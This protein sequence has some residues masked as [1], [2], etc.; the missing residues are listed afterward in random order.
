MPRAT[1]DRYVQRWEQSLQPTEGNCLSE[2]ISPP[3][4]EEIDKMV[5]KLK[6]RLQR[7]LTTKDAVDQ[8]LS[9]LA[10]SLQ[11]P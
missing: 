9:V 8:F 4:A 7:V 6:P 5:A 2:S 11:L 3:T 1:A 10:G